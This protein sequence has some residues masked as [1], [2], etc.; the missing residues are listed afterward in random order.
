[1]SVA[2]F[3]FEGKPPPA[4]TSYGQSVEG[5]P[6]WLSDFTQGIAA[7]ANAIAAEPYQPYGGPRIG[8]HVSKS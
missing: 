3:L 2:D 7:R 6:K 1:M 8:D 4:V 5:M